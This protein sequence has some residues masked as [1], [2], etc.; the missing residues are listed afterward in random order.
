M[1][2]AT[3]ESVGCPYQRARTLILAGADTA[4]AGNSALLDLGLAPAT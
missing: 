3:F 4:P 2:A 1:T